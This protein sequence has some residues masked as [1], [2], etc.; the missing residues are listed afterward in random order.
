MGCALMRLGKTEPALKSLQEAKD[1][2]P[3]VNPV[4]FQLGRAFQQAGMLDDARERR[5]VSRMLAR[6]LGRP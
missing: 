1:I 6:A 4:T 5:R 2:D 3:T